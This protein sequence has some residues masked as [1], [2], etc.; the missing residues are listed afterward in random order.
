MRAALFR[1]VHQWLDDEPKI[2]TDPIVNVLLERGTKESYKA[3]H[4]RAGSPYADTMRAVF[5]LRSRFAEDE[6]EEATR[7]GVRQYVVLG[8]GLDTFAFR[9]PPF[10]ADLRIFEVDHPA[11]QAWKRTRVAALGIDEP[12]NLRWAPVDFERDSLV[13]A[14]VA[15]DFDIDRPTFFSWLGV[16][17]YLTWTAISAVLRFVA[18]LPAPSGVVLDY[19]LP[20][21][22]LN[23][24]ALEM[25]RRSIMGANA[26][27][28]PV[29]TRLASIEWQ[30]RLREIGF[31]RV[32]LFTP[33]ET[34]NRYL[35]ARHDAL[36]AQA[37]V[38]LLS[39]T[40]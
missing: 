8:A 37:W 17:P 20:D 22:A 21:Q 13:D 6:L 14:L 1:A 5:V 34:R 31:S 26:A 35:E 10:A 27:G 24:F 7:R 39:A 40:V 25:T 9:Q 32:S 11:T 30:A 23:G 16:T 3:L 28:E 4:E 36:R 12:D 33:E 19:L 2:L 18:S 15:H 29:R 38:P